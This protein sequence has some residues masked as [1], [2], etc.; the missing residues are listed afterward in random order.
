M[1]LHRMAASTLVIG[2]EGLEETKEVRELVQ[3]GVAGCILFARNVESP[4]QVATLCQR[5][6]READGPLLLCV[7]QEGGRVA[8]LRG[9]PFTDLPAMRIVGG[10]MSETLAYDVGRLL[11]RETRAAG[12]D[13]DFAP[14]L[15]VD[16]NPANPVIGDR[17]LSRDAEI[18]ARLGVA[19]AR[20][21]ESEGVASCG[22]HFPGHG[23]TSQDSHL[24][25]PRLPHG[26]ER[27][28]SVELLPFRAYANAGL[29]AIMTAHVV[30]EAVDPDV[31]ASFS[32]KVQTELLRDELGFRG[33]LIS[34]DLEMKAIAD[35][36][37]MEE[38]AVGAIRAGV[39][40]LLV[41]HRADRQK[42]AI[43][44]LVAEAERSESFMQRLMEASE[45][46]KSFRARFAR[47]APSAGEALQSLTGV[48]HRAL[49][50][51]IQSFFT[52]KST[53]AVSSR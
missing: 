7:D 9:L 42:Q 45:R 50:R 38:A 8:R 5:L 39:D 47:T 29:G 35:R 10:C 27:L 53:G 51:K 40:L 44:G 22:K 1:D 34:D 31:P 24:T 23:D 43:D 13:M 19:I 52:E 28:T 33:G 49:V 4:L 30:F 36:Y 14:V 26:M 21:I 12:F 48:D 25:L 2:F 41:C 3:Q 37:S 17:A 16:T 18:V 32:R 15:D 20:G 46:T 6:K 11:G